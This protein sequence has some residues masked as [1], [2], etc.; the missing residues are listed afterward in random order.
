MC[1]VHIHSEGQFKVTLQFRCRER[2]AAAVESKS[3]KF[4]LVFALCSSFP[5]SVIFSY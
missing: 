4:V 1:T 3:S 2:G 5:G